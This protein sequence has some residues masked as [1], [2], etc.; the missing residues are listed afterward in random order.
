MDLGLIKF[1]RLENFYQL[2]KM[3]EL[4]LPERFSDNFGDPIDQIFNLLEKINR[5]SFNEEIALNYDNAR[6]TH[7]F[8]SLSL[9]L[10]CTQ[11]RRIG[12]NISLKSD[13]NNPYTRDYMSLI[14]FPNGFDP[15]TLEIDEF[16]NYLRSFKSKTYLPM[17]NFPVGE[18]VNVTSVRD[19]FLSAVN[20]LLL[21]MCGLTAPMTTALMY[22]IDEAVNNILHHSYDDKGYL[23][24]QYY[25]SK[26]YLD[27]VI[28][29]IGRTL[30]QSYQNMGRYNKVVLSHN[31][32]MKAALEGKSTKSETIDRGFGIST[33]KDMLISGLNGKYFLWSGNVLNIHNA[34]INDIVNLPQSINWQG[35]YLCLRIPVVPKQGFNPY[36]YMG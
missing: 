17:I 9:P 36:D 6:F 16:S 1:N 8:F 29:D 30:L 15:M 2:I 14:Q 23:L 3:I 34:E 32:A 12:R 10:I 18:G 26:G 7:P 20:Q 21:H 13:F 31:D 22:L 25:P 11:N 33:S 35:V 4:D 19:H 28:A 5:T 24:A 27:I